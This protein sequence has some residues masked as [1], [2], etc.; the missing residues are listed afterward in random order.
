MQFI[1]DDIITYDWSDGDLLF[2]NST[3]FDPALMEKIA[4]AALRCK[5]GTFMITFTKALPNKDGVWK[6][7]EGRSYP[8]S[9]GPATVFIQEKVR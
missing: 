4:D 9:W 7:H 3:C 5:K 1:N 2:A 8:M 6:V